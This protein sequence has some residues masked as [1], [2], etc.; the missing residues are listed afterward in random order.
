VG[1]IVTL[2]FHK[3]PC[4]SDIPLVREKLFNGFLF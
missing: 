4:P 2:K 1:F 3:T